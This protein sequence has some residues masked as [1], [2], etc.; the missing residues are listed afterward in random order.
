MA[1]GSRAAAVRKRPRRPFL[2]SGRLLIWVV[3]AAVVVFLVVY[4]VFQATLT[5]TLLAHYGF[6]SLLTFVLFGLDKLQAKREGRRTS[7]RNLLV[8]SALGGA[9]GGLLGMGIFRHKSTRQ[10]FRIGLPILVFVHG[11]FFLLLFL[12]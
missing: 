10:A 6:V 9:V 3:V 12:R 7:E 4:L 5:Q 8:L 1:F 11:V 2:E